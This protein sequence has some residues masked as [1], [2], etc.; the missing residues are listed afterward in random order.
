MA[1]QRPKGSEARRNLAKVQAVLAGK[2]DK[3]VEF[4]SISG[5]SLRKM[6]IPDLQRLETQLIHQVLNEDRQRNPFGQVKFR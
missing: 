5:R 6:P 2:A 3:D 4:Y 1:T